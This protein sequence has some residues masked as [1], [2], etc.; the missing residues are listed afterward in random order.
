MRSADSTIR[1][2]HSEEELHNC[3]T[4]LRASF[5]TVAHEFGLTEASA[6][7]NAAF[8]TQDNLKRHVEKGLRLYGMFCASSLVGCIAIK[9]SKL[10]EPIFYV[11]RLAVAPERRHRGYGDQL[12]SFALERIRLSGGTIAS[13]GVMDNNE[14]LKTWYLSKGFTQH[15]CRRIAHLPFKVCFM[16]RNVV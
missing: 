1:E 16:S 12:L 6:S 8:T 9:R 5:G 14:I 15:D 3:V 7:T 4:L 11:E 2:L 13:I 10:E